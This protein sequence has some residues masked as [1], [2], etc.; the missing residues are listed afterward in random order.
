MNN[1]TTNGN[2]VNPRFENLTPHDVN[3]IL[4]GGEVLTIPATGVVAR[5]GSHVEQIGSIGVIPVLTA[6]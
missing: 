6:M 1:N 5:V 2:L 4:P 3:L